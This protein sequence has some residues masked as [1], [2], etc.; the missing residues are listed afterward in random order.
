MDFVFMY[1]SSMLLFTLS[2]TCKIPIQFSQSFNQ[3]DLEK[4]EMPTRS[5]YALLYYST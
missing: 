3:E 5:I 4:M 2:L 1:P